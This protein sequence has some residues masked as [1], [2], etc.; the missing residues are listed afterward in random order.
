MAVVISINKLGE[1]SYKSAKSG[2]LSEEQMT[3]ADELNSLL[4]DSI[5]SYVNKHNLSEIRKNK[6]SFYWG[7]GFILRDVFYNSGLIDLAEKELFF[8][9]VRLHMDSF[10]DV[11]PKDDLK[12]RR[13]IPKQF[14]NLAGYPYDVAKNLN[15]S[16]W[17]YLFDNTYLMDNTDFDTWFNDILVSKKYNFNEG[18]TRLWAES[19]N[20]LFNNVDLSDWSDKEFLK[21]LNCTLNIINNLVNAGINIESRDERRVIKKA[22]VKVLKENRRDFILLQKG[23]LK[24]SEYVKSISYKIIS[25]KSV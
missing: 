14:F 2:L 12:K 21:S 13:N 1:R 9:N 19:F 7:L 3:R 5:T 24:A 23:D 25:S 18:F 17:S 4:K 10:Q 6:L 15:W 8:K 22:I 11:F 16:Q 20:L